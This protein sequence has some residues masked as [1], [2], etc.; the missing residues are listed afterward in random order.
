MGIEIRKSD[1]S[2]V[3]NSGKKAMANAPEFIILCR[4]QTRNDKLTHNSVA[5]FHSL[6]A[7]D[8]ATR[9]SLQKLIF[10]SD[11]HKYLMQDS[12]YCWGGGSV[13]L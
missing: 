13:G 10:V 9:G 4:Q 11:R 12:V 3:H 2:P 5:I 1:A 7:L 6:S 8:S